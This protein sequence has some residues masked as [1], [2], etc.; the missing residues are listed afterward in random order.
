MG[1]P[2]GK[3]DSAIVNVENLEISK[4]NVAVVVPSPRKINMEKMEPCERK[5]RSRSPIKDRDVSPT[6]IKTPP[7]RILHSRKDNENDSDT[8]R[9]NSILDVGNDQMFDDSIFTEYDDQNLSCMSSKMTK[10][11]AEKVGKR[12][13]QKKNIWC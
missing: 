4:K 9:E 8:S 7:R 2:D 12:R 1:R 13:S 3:S 5:Y 11:M 6:N 10:K